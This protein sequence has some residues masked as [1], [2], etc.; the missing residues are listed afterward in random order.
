MEYVASNGGA[1]IS[2]QTIEAAS[3]VCIGVGA[4]KEKNIFR[5]EERKEDR[6]DLTLLLSL[7]GD[8]GRGLCLLVDLLSFCKILPPRDR[9]FFRSLVDA[10]VLGT[11]QT[12]V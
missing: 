2:S 3:L 8:D 5:K 12:D 11:L 4:R 7:L 10:A 6:L 9:D 1:S